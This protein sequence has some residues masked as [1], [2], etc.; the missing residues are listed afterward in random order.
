MGGGEIPDG[1]YTSGDEH[2]RNPLGS[3]G[4][5]GDDAHQDL[6]E[7]AVVLQLG[8]GVHRLAVLCL[9][10]GGGDIEGSLDVQTVSLEAGIGHQGQTQLAR[11]NEHRIGGVVVAQKLLD[12]VDQRLPLVADLGAAA[13]GNDGQILAHLHLAHVQSVGQSRG[14][15]IGR[16]CI[17]QTLQVSQVAGEPLQHRFGNFHIT[18]HILP[19]PIFIDIFLYRYIYTL[20]IPPVLSFCKSSFYRIFLYIY[21]RFVKGQAQLVCRRNSFRSLPRIRF[22]SLEI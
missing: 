19:R 11:A 15:D 3:G 10:D 8:D 7:L 4:G 5:D 1:L 18:F 16:G 21:K 22:S 17:R 20:I 2:I 14:G 6:V 12:V 9:F 13:V